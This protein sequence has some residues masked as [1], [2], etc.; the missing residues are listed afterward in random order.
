[1]ITA[2]DFFDAT[3]RDPEQDDLE[4]CN[5]NKAGTVGHRQCG[6]CPKHDKPRFECMYLHNG[7]HKS[8]KK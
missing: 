8:K 6:W 2:E 7:K 5:C 4:R 3:G 1:M